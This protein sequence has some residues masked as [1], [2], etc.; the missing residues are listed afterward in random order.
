LELRKTEP[1]A[2]ELA[3]FLLFAGNRYISLSNDA[4]KIEESRIVRYNFLN[5]DSER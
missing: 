4:D 1:P 5:F 3:A 2:E